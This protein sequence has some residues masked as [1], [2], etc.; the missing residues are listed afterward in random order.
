MPDASPRLDYAAPLK[1]WERR[2]LILLLVLALVF[3]GV[4]EL[5]SAFL[6]RRMGDLEVY[7]RAAWAVRVGA[8]I[9]WM[10]DH[11]GFHYHY[12]PVFAILM[13]PLNDPIPQA[14]QTWCLPYWAIVAIWYSLNAFV[15]LPLAVCWLAK[16]LEQT[17]SDPALRTLPRGC[18]G[19]WAL[20]I[21]P[22][23]ACL[24]PIGHTLMRGQVSL[25]L[26]F[27]LAGMM[28]AFIRGRSWQAGFWLSGAICLKVI[29]AFLLLY[30]LWR[31]DYR[32]LTA[33]AG[34]LVI[35]LGLIPV[36]VFGPTRT[37]TYYHEWVD[38]LLLPA[39]AKGGDDH[40]R[41]KE[42]LEVPATHSQS[43]LAVF[44]NTLYPDLETRPPQ[45]SPAVR[46]AALLVGGVLTL[47]TLLAAGWRRTDSGPEVVLF[48]G[49]LVLL[50]LLLSPICHL[51][52]FSLSVPLIL[53]FLFLF[54][55]NE[56]TP[57]LGKRGILLVTGYFV[58]NLL[59]QLPGLELVRD[60]GLAMYMA[61][62]LW[63]LAVIL[64]W[65]RV[66]SASATVSEPLA[67]PRA[68]A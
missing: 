32:C 4:V 50:M 43:L 7:L 60:L 15:F 49:A 18:R 13:V 53:A 55:G 9:Y 27:L 16:A 45:A 67:L 25:L 10:T 61:V 22:I 48:L 39:L 36:A 28:V 19:W 21:L 47:L 68:A 57:Y 66:G 37:V 33:C 62:G 30:P 8:D 51:H 56:A 42:L 63:L 46:R 26:L 64:L 31:R 2:G 5:R 3:G 34:G 59:P 24:P 23:L 1:P 65:K 20:R 29:P 14:G 58:A 17:S 12:P 35:G 38:Q 54:R 11:N 6:Q 40:S 52:Y 41:A 44:H